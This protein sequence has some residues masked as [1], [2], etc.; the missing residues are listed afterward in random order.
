MSRIRSAFAVTSLAL[1]AL[2][3]GYVLVQ[4]S[5]APVMERPAPLVPPSEPAE[6]PAPGAE[7]ESELVRP[8]GSP[9]ALDCSA[10]RVV[11]RDIKARFA[12]DVK[13][14][15]SSVFADL[16]TSWLDPHGLWSAAVDAP[17]AELV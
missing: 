5:R 3:S 4:G 16:V 11:V 13:R 10:A 12:V 1:A 17:I 9:A 6:E 14:P 7:E 8:D 15:S 2:A